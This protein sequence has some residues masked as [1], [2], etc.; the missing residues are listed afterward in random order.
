[1]CLLPVYNLEDNTVEYDLTKDSREVIY[2]WVYMWVYMRICM[3]IY[4]N[5]YECV[6]YLYT[7]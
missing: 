2:M 4:V 1:M 5:K 3:W 6:Y 7:I